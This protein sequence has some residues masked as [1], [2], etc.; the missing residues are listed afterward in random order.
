VQLRAL[1]RAS[2]AVVSWNPDAVLV[3]GRLPAWSEAEDLPATGVDPLGLRQ[4]GLDFLGQ[5]TQGQNNVVKSCRQHAIL[6]WAVWRFG[7]NLEESGR[8]E[9]A[10]RSEFDAFIQ[11]VESI[12]LAGQSQLQL[13]NAPN[14]FG[15]DGASRLLARGD[16]IPLAFEAYG[17]TPSTGAMDPANY[18]PFMSVV[19]RDPSRTVR[20]SGLGFV[21]RDHGVYAATEARGRGV[22]EA[23]DGLLRSSPHYDILC[24]TPLAGDLPLDVALDLAAHGLLV[25][26]A[27]LQ[28]P[29]RSPYVA[30]LFDLDEALLTPP[31]DHRRRT[32]CYLLHLLG[33]DGGDIESI[34]RLQLRGPVRGE[35]P[36]QLWHIGQLWRV[37]QLRQLQ[38]SSLEAWRLILE[39]LMRGGVRSLDG[40]V[41]RIGAA[42]ARSG[43]ENWWKV[44]VA[45]A[46]DRFEANAASAD[47]DGWAGGEAV[48]AFPLL[49]ELERQTR[50][51]PEDAAPAALQLTLGS[52]AI[53]R[54]YTQQGRESIESFVDHGR[55]LRV[56]L[57]LFHRWAEERA[58]LNLE[59]FLTEL[60]LEFVLQQHTAIAAARLDA[61]GQR[62]RF[63][64]QE[65]GWELL[66]KVKLG[67]LPITQDRL[68][69]LLELLVD[70]AVLH[71]TGDDYTVTEAG[72]E[73]YGQSLALMRE[74]S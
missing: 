27:Q 68:E 57:G 48:G 25:D 20:A 51:E 69:S 28:R 70:C 8:A 33:D 59:E 23:L 6:V 34:R 61:T 7:R 31:W 22:A 1:A 73:V 42:L 63:C 36:D 9:G 38:R 11:A 18:R 26:D 64:K 14:V 24:Q 32:L 55:R 65:D 74:D 54:S 43:Q 44:S 56:S 58:E 16:R 40:M 50:R 4:V 17:R 19:W 66:D 71:R 60:L 12:Q 10:T 72:R 47:L 21:D 45:E 41:G 29:E 13:G 46:L 53:L 52:L 62:L 2:G 67:R 37:F 39:F 30:A 15:V 49:R 5:L 3:E 35:T